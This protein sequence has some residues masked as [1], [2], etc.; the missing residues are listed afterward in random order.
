MGKESKRKL[1]L[2]KRY[3][4]SFFLVVISVDF[5]ITLL[6][7][8]IFSTTKIS[9]ARDFSVA[10]LDQ[11][12]T[13][14]D[15]L[16]SS[17]ST[18]ADQIVTDDSTAPVLYSES[19]DRLQETRACSELR[20]IKSTHPYLRFAGFYNASTKRYI[21]NAYVGYREVYDPTPLY[22]ALGNKRYACI[23]RQVGEAY[24]VQDKQKIYVYTFVF[25]AINQ[26]SGDTNLIILDVN[27]SYFNEILNNIRIDGVKQKIIFSDDSGT[28]I[29]RKEATGA[30]QTFYTMENDSEQDLLRLY[31]DASESG[32][33]S[34]K[35]AQ[36]ESWFITY[37]KTSETNWMITNVVPYSSVLDGIGSLAGLT[38]LMFF[39]TLGLG[40]MLSLKMSKMLY[41]PIKLL[42][43]NY[44]KTDAQSKEN[45]LEQLNHAFAEMYSKTDQLEQG[46]IA[47]Y[48]E[49]KN[50]LIRNLLEGNIDR[51][52]KSMQAYEKLDIPLDSPHYS[53]LLVECIQR[54]GMEQG[55][56]IHQYA[57]ENIMRE[58][59][60][61]HCALDFLRLTENR[62]AAL[63]YPAA[64]ELPQVLTKNLNIVTQTMGREFSVVT[65]ICVGNVVDAWQNINMC[66]E[67][68]RISLNS[69][70]FQFQGQV[71]LFLEMPNPMRAEQYFNGLHTKFSEYVRGNDLETCA[72][73]FDHAL[74][75][76]SNISFKTAKAYFKHVAMSVLDNFE[77]TFDK[78]DASLTILLGKL[79]KIDSNQSVSSLKE[80]LM[81]FFAQ[82]M[83][84]LELNKKGSNQDA[85][86][87]T[88]AYIHQNYTNP[89]LAI[90]MAADIVNLSPA[91]LGKVFTIVTG[92]SFN[93]Y[94]NQLRMKKAS[95]LL[96][97]TKQP[98][99]TISQAVGILNTNYF[100]SLFKKQFNTTPANYRKKFSAGTEQNTPE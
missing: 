81:D 82:L 30:S 80:I 87:R 84:R 9:S 72:T 64:S 88:R 2:G 35:D 95:E 17:L 74:T 34:Y 8:S 89:E 40:L 96:R 15:I 99:H 14:T 53:V 47:S 70:S 75:S 36:G 69:H 46:L 91:Y 45:E 56:F 67:Q 58:I 23:M 32:S 4:W 66:Y 59:I 78:E 13:A 39:I 19:M 93:D 60:G 44:V 20:N 86:E 28:V 5:F 22:E 54:E 94:L 37:A 65:T 6:L 57:L 10:Q 97:E 49:S 79:E 41:A 7:F 25:R 24:P 98:V 51:V 3:L 18:V 62:F 16:Y 12:C 50:Q 43:E 42:Y 63:M 33:K 83:H 48:H 76:M 61:S 31:Q 77:M 90:P 68:T 21:S 100:F 11:V 27:E 71:F 26:Y 55:G 92:F 52:K 73:E 85:A 1:K 29:T 38:M